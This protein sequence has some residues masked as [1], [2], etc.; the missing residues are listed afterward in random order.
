MTKKSYPKHFHGLARVSTEKQAD[1]YLSLVNQ[2]K[3]IREYANSLGVIAPIHNEEGSGGLPWEDREIL[4]QVLREAKMDNAAILVTAVDRLAREL[5][6]FHEIVRLGIPVC[7]VGRGKITRKELWDELKMAKA[8]HDR[9]GRV[10]KQDHAGRK[11]SGKKVGGT[12]TYETSIRGG[13]AG[14]L[15]AGDRD[16]RMFER[17]REHPEWTEMSHKALAEHL[18]AVGIRNVVKKSGFE[19]DW[20]RNSVQK[21]RARY[22]Q[23]QAFEADLDVEDGIPPLDLNGVHTRVRAADREK[24]MDGRSSDDQ[25]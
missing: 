19:N 9:I 7:V 17:L 13:I 22:R 20:T 5:T 15:R 21:L 18:N 25:P 16:R 14:Y 11:V 8:E 3:A 24:E 6:V 12:F 2:T 10:A 23:E 1:D 4:K